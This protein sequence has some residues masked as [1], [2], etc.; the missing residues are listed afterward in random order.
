MPFQENLSGNRNWTDD[1]PICNFTGCGYSTNQVYLRDG[2][3]KGESK[4]DYEKSCFCCYD[5][6]K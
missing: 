3:I 2:R 5:A 4:L 1:L 6:E